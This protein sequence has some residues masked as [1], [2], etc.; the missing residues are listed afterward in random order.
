MSETDDR[1][2]RIDVVALREFEAALGVRPRRPRGPDDHLRGLVAAV[3]KG[4]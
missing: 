4:W 2:I 3:I 1:I